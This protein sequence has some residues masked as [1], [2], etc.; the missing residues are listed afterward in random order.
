MAETEDRQ[1]S[2]RTGILNIQSAVTP[3]IT[4]VQ[5]CASIFS[6]CKSKKLTEL[7]TSCFGVNLNDF[8]SNETGKLQDQ[9]VLVGM[10]CI[11]F[12]SKSLGSENEYQKKVLQLSLN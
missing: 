8:N 3:V 9:N 6:S 1:T 12:Q 5:N 7:I 10:V 11:V 2:S 4:R